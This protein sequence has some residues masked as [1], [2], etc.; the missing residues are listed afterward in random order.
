MLLSV[1][2]CE[3]VQLALRRSRCNT[4]ASRFYLDMLEAHPGSRTILNLRLLNMKKKKKQI[5]FVQQMFFKFLVR[6]NLEHLVCVSHCNVIVPLMDACLITE[7]K[8]THSSK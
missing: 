1:S 3:Y 2:I 6:G 5:Q 7:Y 8:T 4:D